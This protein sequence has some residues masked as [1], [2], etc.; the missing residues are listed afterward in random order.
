V[1]VPVGSEDSKAVL[2]TSD[3]EEGMGPNSSDGAETSENAKA[4]SSKKTK[5][6]AHSL[7]I[8]EEDNERLQPGE[9]LND[10]LIDFWMQ[11][12]VVSLYAG[13]L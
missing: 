13:S 6:R 12:Y 4:N 5:S 8:C 1:V 7:T 3:G 11:W 9:F 2:K 10:T